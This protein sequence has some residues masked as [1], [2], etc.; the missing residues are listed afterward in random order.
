MAD[1][2]IALDLEVN[3]KKGDITLEQLNN[4]F[5]QIGETIQEQKDILIE[6]EQELIE[7]E[8]IQ[9]STSA[10]NFQRQGELKTKSEQLKFAIKDQRASLRELNNERG[11][12]SG[13]IKNVSQENV[14]YNK[15]IQAT[16][17]LTGGMATKVIKLYEGFTE[18]VKGIKA[19]NIGLSGMK[20]A[21]IATGLGALVVALGLIVAYWEDIVG[22]ISGASA[23]QNKLLADTEKTKKANEDALA[24][25]EASESSLKLQGMSEKEI[26]ELKKKQTDE[27]ISA[28]EAQ[29]QQQKAMRDS[30]IAAAERNQ[31]IAAGIIGFLTAPI[32]FLLAAVDSLTYGL[33]KVSSIEATNLVEGYVK[34]AA[35]L[36]GFDPDEVKKEGDE[37][38][39]ETEKQLAA[40]KN[41]RDG[42]ILKGKENDKKAADKSKQAKEKADKAEEK[43]A[44]EKADALEAIRVGEIDTEAERR[45]EELDKIDKYYEDL[46]TKAEKYGKDTAELEDARDAKKQEVFDKQAA[47][48]AKEQ[49]K[50]DKATLKEQETLI[51]KLE[52]DKEQEELK[53]EEQRADI[54]RREAILLE[55]KT[56]T[57]TQRNQ[58]EANFSKERKAIEKGEAEARIELNAQRVDLALNTLHAL[59]GLVQAF[60]KD[61][62]ESQKKAFNANKAFGIGQAIISTA[63]GISNALTAGGNPLKLATGTQFVEA[64]IVAA[65]GAAQIATISKTQFKGAAIAPTPPPTANGVG[66]VGFLPR[67]FTSPVI[68]IDAPTTKVIVTETDIRNVSRNVDGVYSRAIVVQ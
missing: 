29:L 45:Q 63:V 51:K 11:K 27:I 46:I 68:D 53:F 3:I 44:K 49:A 60:A 23:E 48:D 13:A 9:A 8:R 47:R 42:F 38:I 22:F 16:D 61:D 15:L 54:A 34:G 30:Q 64:G 5:K 19:F 20:K 40:L 32:T 7:V 66:D 18:G 4:E 55:D 24:A 12:A 35:S 26:L 17:K 25:T 21:L 50:K 39:K 6:F 1:K 43:A 58:V 31:K 10:N 56:L 33:S 14:K 67:G 52:A 37:T 28:T 57:E 65:S 2:K 41:K 62:E 36:I 59:N